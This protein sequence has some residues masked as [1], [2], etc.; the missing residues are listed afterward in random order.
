VSTPSGCSSSKFAMLWQTADNQVDYVP[1]FSVEWSTNEARLHLLPE[2]GE[3]ESF[4]NSLQPSRNSLVI[5]HG[6]RVGIC[7]ITDN[8]YSFVGGRANFSLTAAVQRTDFTPSIE[9]ALGGTSADRLGEMRARRLLLN[10]N[11]YVE[12][13]DINAITDELFISGQDTFV[14]VQFSPFPRL[15]TQFGSDPGRF[16]EIAWICA[17]AQLKLSACVVDIV[18]LQ[19]G[20]IRSGVSMGLTVSFKG[21]RK[22]KYVNRPAYEMSIEGTCSLI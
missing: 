20:L 12:S 2:G 16:L 10:E 5:A 9:V 6:H 22:K 8:K 15:Y 1:A 3:D 19:L 14:R 17:A 21:R 11:P 13:R 4:L 18:S 7:Q